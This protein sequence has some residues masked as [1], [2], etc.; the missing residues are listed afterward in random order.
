MA[1]VIRNLGISG[2]PLGVKVAIIAGLS[3]TA[4][5]GLGDSA[6]KEAKNLMDAVHQS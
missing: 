2:Y 1:T 3:V 5:I 6:V 4:I